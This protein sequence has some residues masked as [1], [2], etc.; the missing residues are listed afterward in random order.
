M[1]A[2]NHFQKLP[3][4]TDRNEDGSPIIP[5]L[6]STQADR[7]VEV[8][9]A[10][11]LEAETTAAAVLDMDPAEWDEILTTLCRDEWYGLIDDAIASRV[12]CRLLQEQL[13]AY[14]PVA[15]PAQ[16]ETRHAATAKVAARCPE[17]LSAEI[18]CEPFDFGIDSETGHHDAGEKYRCTACGAVGDAED[19]LV[20][21][22]RVTRMPAAREIAY[23][24]IGN[25]MAVR[26]R[27]VGLSL[28]DEYKAKQA[29]C[30]HAKRDPRGTCYECGA[31]AASAKSA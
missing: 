6:N 1:A 31:R 11:L 17:C 29:R 20:S 15:M 27:G 30:C 12:A 18:R 5:E 22:P 10:H 2:H 25:G 3:P 7:A 23:A 4:K 21:A 13:A 14:L 28:M 26:T 9:T 24:L 16:R 8:L 19:V